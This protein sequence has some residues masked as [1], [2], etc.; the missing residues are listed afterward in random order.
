MQSCGVFLLLRAGIARVGL[1]RQ[2]IGNRDELLQEGENG[3]CT[4]TFSAKS[5]INKN[6][7]LPMISNKQTNK[8]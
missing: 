6:P 2:G 8:K 4:D 5:T 7:K 1:S 3:G